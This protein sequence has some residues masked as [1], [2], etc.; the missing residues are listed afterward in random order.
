MGFPLLSYLER[1]VPTLPPSPPPEE[2]QMPAALR[3][4][5]ETIKQQEQVRSQGGRKG[6]GAQVLLARLV[7]VLRKASPGCL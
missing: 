7:V 6:R 2:W 5:G 3:S 4:L 1:L